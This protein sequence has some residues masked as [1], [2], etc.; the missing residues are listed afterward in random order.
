M[1]NTLTPRQK[2]ILQH[3]AGGASNRETARLLGTHRTTVD[4]TIIHICQRYEIATTNRTTAVLE[5]IRRGDV[6][7]QLAYRELEGRR[8]AV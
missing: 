4:V 6:N 2:E 8:R 3:I 7:E 5:G 1:M